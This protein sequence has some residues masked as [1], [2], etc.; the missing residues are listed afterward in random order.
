[1]N[2]YR[3]ITFAAQ[4]I[5][6]VTEIEA[7]APPVSSP[8]LTAAIARCALPIHC[9]VS[10]CGRYVWMMRTDPDCAVSGIRYTMAEA[11]QAYLALCESLLEHPPAAPDAATSPPMAGPAAE[12]A[13]DSL[14]SAASSFGAGA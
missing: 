9:T 4:H 10:S 5:H 2:T 7:C 12:A 14:V 1:V 11:A 13:P 3:A 8:Y 6:T